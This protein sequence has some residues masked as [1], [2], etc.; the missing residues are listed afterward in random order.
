MKLICQKK[1]KHQALDAFIDC[2]K[3]NQH[4]LTQNENTQSINIRVDMNL[5]NEYLKQ[6]I[7]SNI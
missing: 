2:G 6:L 3:K 7:L 1:I 4:S 5:L